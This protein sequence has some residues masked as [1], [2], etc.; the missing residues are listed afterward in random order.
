MKMPAP[1]TQNPP[2]NGFQEQ[3]SDDESDLRH[4][5]FGGVHI[6]QPRQQNRQPEGPYIQRHNIEVVAPQVSP[7]NPRLLDIL[8]AA[9]APAP[10]REPN[11]PIQI[12]IFQREGPN[13]Q[14]EYGARR[15]FQLN[16]HLR[17]YLHMT[18]QCILLAS[19]HF[20]GLSE[21]GKRRAFQSLHEAHNDLRARIIAS[22]QPRE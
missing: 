13:N 3:D 7:P 11:R 6:Q 17:D 15:V 5:V 8:E 19:L 4:I 2:Q 1:P 20:E 21:E 12:E 9:Q 10:Q 14:P 18:S 22:H 16:Y